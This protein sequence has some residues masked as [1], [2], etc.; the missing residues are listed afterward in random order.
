MDALTIYVFVII[1]VKS[2]KQSKAR[3]LDQTFVL[4]DL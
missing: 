3:E 4:K 1:F 2:F